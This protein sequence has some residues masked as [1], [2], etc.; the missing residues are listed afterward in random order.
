MNKFLPPLAV[1]AVMLASGCVSESL[2]PR[3]RTSQRPP[4]IWESS[5]GGFQLQRDSR[6]F[7]PAQIRPVYNTRYA[8][9]DALSPTPNHRVYTS[10]SGLPAPTKQLANA[11]IGYHARHEI[12]AANPVYAQ[13]SQPA[14]TRQIFSPRPSGQTR[15]RSP[16]LGARNEVAPPS[17]S[18]LAVE[19][20]AYRLTIP[21]SPSSGERLAS[22]GK[23]KPARPPLN[24]PPAK[25]SSLVKPAPLGPGELPLALPSPGRTGFAHLAA[26]P[27]LPEIDVRGI[28][29]GTPV[30]IPDPAEPGKTIQFRVP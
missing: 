17:Q 6:F 2:A 27:N 26:H 9:L 16:S 4:L 7:A 23:G 13:R 24:Q 22:G 3:Y 18:P 25:G 1:A 20:S 11:S 14:E 15:T 30:E 29:P 19:D 10:V 5:A 12:Y 28:L 21:R 8:S